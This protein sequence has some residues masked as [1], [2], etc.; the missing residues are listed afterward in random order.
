MGRCLSVLCGLLLLAS[1]AAAEVVRIEVLSRA[2]AGT[3]ERII[4]R[5]HFAA[6]PDNAANRAV[7]DIAFA[8]VNAD[9]LVEYSSD[10][11][12]F[13]P[14]DP[15]EARGTV[16][17]EVVNR[18]R[19][20]S[21]ILFSEGRT[22][23]LNPENWDLGDRF[24]LEQGFTLAFLGW[25]ADVEPGQGLG[26][27]APVAPVE[28]Q[29]RGSYIEDGVQPSPRGFRLPYC[30]F[31]AAAQPD[32]ALTFRARFEDAPRALPRD[33]WLFMQDGCAVL[34]ASEGTR[35]PGIYEIVY[36]AKGSP[37]F[38]LGLAAIRDFA[39]YLRHGG[40]VTTLRENPALVQRVIGFG[41]SQSAR[42]LREFVRDG[43]NA[44][45]QGRQAF[46]ALFIASAG[47]G[48]GSFNHRFAMPGQ[49]G[50]SVLSVLRPVDLPPFTDEGL[51]ARARAQRVVPRIVTTLSST[52]YWARA[53]S[54]TYTND[55]ATQD[56]PLAPTSRLYLIAGTPHSGAPIP[57]QRDVRYRG[58]RHG[59]NF[60]EQRWPLRAL[61][62]DLD[63]W[64][65]DGTEPPPSRVP[66]LAE[67]QLVRR[68][69]VRFPAIPGLPFASYLPPV[70]R[71]N[72]GPRFATDRIISE[73][74]MTG[75]ELPVRVPQVDADG[76]DM[77]GIRVPE[78]GVPLGT[79]TGWNI[80]EPTLPGLR[81]LAGLAGSFE[82]FARTR[83]ER[84]RTGDARLSI[85]E[86]YRN[87]DDYLARVREYAEILV[88]E[89]VALATD[90]DAI[91]SLAAQLW[92]A[93]AN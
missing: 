12:W 40:R 58:Y 48:G 22:R 5:V 86:R 71:L 43:F 28:G 25:Q 18:G 26:F 41:Y 35:S 55:D 64:L 1:T 93:V 27:E 14:K 8:P 81:Y 54:L 66:T 42:L 88:K 74:P 6:R 2:D 72:L 29:V 61:L 68:E 4:A 56:V 84:E 3:H 80:S 44:D 16:F 90:V 36:N 47:A 59:L 50:N 75:E 45:E 57:R 60:A 46:D 77:G 10:L 73:P 17:L 62:L 33:A 70:F 21:L 87:R 7:A 31:N 39:A 52:E 38:G 91:I 30:V 67:R 9:G 92:E 63:A 37:V 15:G 11:L 51:L 24:F 34:F 19:D 23:D 13:Q 82:P 89:R 20:Q 65:R 49:A 53:A 76:N 78:I 85:A 32:V 69:N 79:F 83:D